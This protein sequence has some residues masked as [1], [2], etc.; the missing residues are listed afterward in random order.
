MPI[1][2]AQDGKGGLDRGCGGAGRRM[3]RDKATLPVGGRAGRLVLAAAA[4]L[5]DKLLASEHAGVLRDSVAWPIAEL[6]EAEVSG[7]TGTPS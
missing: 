5:G 2:A 4:E 3:G 6:M 1:F 7:L